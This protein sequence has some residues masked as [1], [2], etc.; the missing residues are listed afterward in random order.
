LERRHTILTAKS[1]D[2]ESFLQFALSL[3]QEGWQ[4]Q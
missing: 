4:V 3:L 2:P 1:E